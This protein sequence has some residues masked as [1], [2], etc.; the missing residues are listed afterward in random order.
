M[1]DVV[2]SMVTEPLFAVISTPCISTNTALKFPGASVMS[3]ESRALSFVLLQEENHNA[4]KMI[5]I[6]ITIF[7]II[8]QEFCASLVRVISFSSA[9]N[10]ASFPLH[11][12]VVDYLALAVHV[13]PAEVRYAAVAVIAED[14]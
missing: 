3:T 9:I 14:G 2:L 11:G 13:A 10:A 5:R 8:E 6:T 4:G 12:F 7:F 1:P